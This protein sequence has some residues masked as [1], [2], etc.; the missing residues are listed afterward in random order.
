MEDMLIDPTTISSTEKLC[1]MI[2]D[3]LCRAEVEFE[4]FKN[5]YLESKRI[6]KYKEIMKCVEHFI[7]YE[8]NPKYHVTKE[9][10]DKVMVFW[11]NTE[12]QLAVSICIQNLPIDRI[13][14]IWNKIFPNHDI[15]K[16]LD[17]WE[18]EGNVGWRHI[19]YGCDHDDRNEGILL[20]ILTN[21]YFY[22]EN[23]VEK[24]LN[25]LTLIELAKITPE[26]YEV[27]YR[28]ITQ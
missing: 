9:Y 2:L 21:K 10:S 13:K 15:E 6:E 25:E 28:P 8:D 20:E 24:L 23:D 16:I 12:Y 7:N 1:F 11:S 27:I 19:L 14:S 22:S 5:E 18:Q 3:H 4:K 26:I 17:F